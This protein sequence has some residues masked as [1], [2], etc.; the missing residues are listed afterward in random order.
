MGFS[1][2]YIELDLFDILFERGLFGLMLT[3]GM[4][5]VFFFMITRVCFFS[6]KGK[7]AGV[8]FFQIFIGLLLSVTSGHI[9]GS[10]ILGVY[11]GIYF[12]LILV[13][14]YN[15]KVRTRYENL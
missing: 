11:H 13:Y 3:Y 15:M 5:F 14:Y 12:S 4:W 10:G 1:S 6:T 8:I 7:L 9:V 2:K